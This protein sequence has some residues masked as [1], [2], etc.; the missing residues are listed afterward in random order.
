MAVNLQAVPGT[1]L[2]ITPDN[3]GNMTFSTGPGVGNVA[4]TINSNSNVTMSG[5]TVNT[6]NTAQRG[7]SSGSM[8]AGSILQCQ[9]T[10]VNG[11]TSTTSTSY[12]NITSLAATITPTSNTSKIMIQAYITVTNSGQNGSYIIVTRNG[13]TMPASLGSSANTN[14]IFNGTGGTVGASCGFI[15]QSGTTYTVVPIRCDYLDSPATTS[16]VTYQVQWRTGSGGTV[17][18][19]YQGT[20]GTNADFGY[21]ASTITVWEVAQ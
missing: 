11:I 16:P 4:M 20:T 5:I 12:V 7:I 18:L 6:L 17:Y 10:T 2:V 1:G 13:S 15:D 21:F 19:N 8:P 9:S 14:W 3:S